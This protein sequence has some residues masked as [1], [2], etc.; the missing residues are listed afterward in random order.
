MLSH[1]LSDGLKFLVSIQVL[2]ILDQ[3]IK[4]EHSLQNV[5]KVS[6]SIILIAEQK[7][8]KDYLF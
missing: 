2:R 4:E 8:R 6:R 1:C 7:V 3:S 5:R